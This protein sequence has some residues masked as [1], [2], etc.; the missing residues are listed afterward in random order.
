[1]ARV[2]TVPVARNPSAQFAGGSRWYQGAP[3]VRPAAEEPRHQFVLPEEGRGAR[4][5]TLDAQARRLDRGDPPIYVAQHTAPTTTA[6][7]HQATPP[8]HY[9]GARTIGRGG[10]AVQV[11][12]FTT[13]A[14]AEARLRE[15]RQTAGRLLTAASDLTEPVSQ[16]TRTLY[17]ARFAGLEAGPA[18]AT[19][20][21]LR[22]Q[23][24]DCF[25]TRLH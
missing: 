20:T 7:L 24:V 3:N 21:A 16:G 23:R 8:P 10:F 11:G 1:M 25:V 18:A 15:V 6:A 19:C 17:R 13:A 22:R 14:E 5:S 2:R 9:V 12:A 4:P